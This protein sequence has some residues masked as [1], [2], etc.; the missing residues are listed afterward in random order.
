[1]DVARIKELLSPQTIHV[2]LA[3]FLC[4]DC[5]LNKYASMEELKK[6]R[7]DLNLNLDKMKD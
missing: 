4:V 6:Q 5:Y 2:D 3:D 7:W 1:M